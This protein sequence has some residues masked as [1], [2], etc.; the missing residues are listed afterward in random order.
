LLWSSTTSLD[1]YTT[2]FGCKE[3]GFPLKYIGIP[4]HYRK[5]S[6]TDWKRVEEYF[7]KR[8]SSWK[9]KH[10]STRGRLTLIN[11]VLSSLLMYMMS[12]FSIPKGV[13]KK[14]DY[15]QSRFFKQQEEKKK[16]HLAK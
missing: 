15:F 11:S 8:L 4:I 3:W 1:Q 10:L 5:F 7:E 16:Y 2:L 14:L 9:G 12:L 13:Q 6:N